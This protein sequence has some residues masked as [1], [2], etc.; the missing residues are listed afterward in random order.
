MCQEGVARSCDWSVEQRKATRSC[1]LPEAAEAVT[2]DPLCFVKTV[3][4]AQGLRAMANGGCIRDGFP[5]DALKTTVLERKAGL[6]SRTCGGRP[7]QRSGNISC[8]TESDANQVPY[9]FQGSLGG[10]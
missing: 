5:R 8:H 4:H 9:N 6:C 3:L 1:S 10:R 7:W 2:L